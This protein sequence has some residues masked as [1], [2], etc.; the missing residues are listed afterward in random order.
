V[1]ATGAPLFD[2]WFA[3]EPSTGPEDFRRRLN[4]PAD[5]PLVL[6]ACSYDFI[7]PREPAFVARWLDALRA[8]PDERLRGASV[9]IRPHPRSAVRWEESPLS[10]DPGVTVWPPAGALPTDEDSKASY[11]DS[12]F[13]SAAVVGINTSAFVESAI[14]GRSVFTVLD[15]EFADTQE[16]TLHFHHLLRANG[17]PLTVAHSL[18]EHLDQLAGEL[19]RQVPDEQARRFVH[20]FVRPAGVERP[21]LSVMVEALERQMHAPAPAAVARPLRQ[22]LGR[23]A[24]RPA[25]E[26]AERGLL[27]PAAKRRRLRLGKRLRRRLKPARRRLRT[28]RRTGRRVARRAAGSLPASLRSRSGPDAQTS[29]AEPRESDGIQPASVAQDPTPARPAGSPPN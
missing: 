21:A 3:R 18:A 15:S 22:T 27:A 23:F 20:H 11:F 16:G 9:L 14:V 5:R 25:A 7:A 17:G 1:V 6:Y 26:L 28:T 29:V 12:L 19:A 8:H 4:F 10:A 2:Q 13:H 24:L